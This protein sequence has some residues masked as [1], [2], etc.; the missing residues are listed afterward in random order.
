M[1][2]GSL[3]LETLEGERQRGSWCFSVNVQTSIVNIVE[4]GEL[5]LFNTYL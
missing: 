4:V 2:G 3:E 1:F 5:K